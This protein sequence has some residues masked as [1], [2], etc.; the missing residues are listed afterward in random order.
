[1]PQSRFFTYFKTILTLGLKMRLA[2][3]LL[4]TSMIRYY[5]N[6]KRFSEFQLLIRYTFGL[7]FENIRT[8]VPEL[9]TQ[10][11][12]IQF[13]FVIFSRLHSEI[14]FWRMQRVGAAHFPFLILVSVV[15]F[16]DNFCDL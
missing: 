8:A 4:Y 9:C 14:A 7:F 3:L 6:L 2:Q 15:F 11:S 13:L 12:Q 1:M 16:F 10:S 5:N